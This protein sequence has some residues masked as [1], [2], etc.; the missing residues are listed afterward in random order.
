MHTGAPLPEVI[1]IIIQ[2]FSGLWV[3]KVIS[4]ALYSE[5]PEFFWIGDEIHLQPDMQKTI[6]GRVQN[7][8]FSEMRSENFLEDPPAKF[9]CGCL[10]EAATHSY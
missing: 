6:I 4:P 10:E 8:S 5:G 2:D 7:P 3:L 9:A 1:L